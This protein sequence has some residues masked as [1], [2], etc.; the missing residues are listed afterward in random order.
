MYVNTLIC[1]VGI[2]G[3]NKFK[4][5]TTNN[6]CEPRG[7]TWTTLFKRSHLSLFTSFNFN[8]CKF[9]AIGI[10]YLFI[11]KQMFNLINV[12]H[13]H[14]NCLILICLILDDH[15]AVIIKSSR[16]I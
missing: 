9:R 10:G 14:R 6:S 2:K 11:F 13:K 8:R 15:I 7:K 1:H 4:T 12:N 3:L 5:T 16:L